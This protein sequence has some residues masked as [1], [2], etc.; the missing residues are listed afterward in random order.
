MVY[1]WRYQVGKSA[2]LQL[3]E[4]A[5]AQAKAAEEKAAYLANAANN[6]DENN[7]KLL[8]DAADIAD[9]K[10]AFITSCAPCHGPEAQGVVGP[11]LT[12]AYW[13]HG[14]AVKDIFSTIKYGVP[15]KGMK[16][17]KEDFSPKQLA[18]LTAY[19][20][21]IQG[22][23]TVNRKLKKVSNIKESKANE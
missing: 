20:K 1:L 2:P 10:K 22:T 7:V 18:Q 11:N 17:W 6:I 15:E 23:K 3:E 4:L 16:S 21:S 19:I 9:G 13:L 14:G 12:D 8:T 5:I